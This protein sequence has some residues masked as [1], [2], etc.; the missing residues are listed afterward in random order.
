MNGFD[1]TIS[2][3]PSGA[4]NSSPS[5]YPYSIPVAIYLNNLFIIPCLPLRAVLILDN[6]GTELMEAREILQDVC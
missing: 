4:N 1:G 3:V 6:S 2:E 5:D